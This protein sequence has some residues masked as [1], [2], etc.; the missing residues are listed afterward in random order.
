M[1][2]RSTEPLIDGFRP[3]F[4][5]QG[6]KPELLTTSLRDTNSFRIQTFVASDL[7]IKKD[8]STRNLILN[9]L[10]IWVPKGFLQTTASNAL[11]HYESHAPVPK[12]SFLYI[13]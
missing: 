8:N 4:D 10:V 12:F 9:Y 6:Q 2:S 1:I 11:A 7:D 3:A 13:T 5:N